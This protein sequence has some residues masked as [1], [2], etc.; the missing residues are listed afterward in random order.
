[1]AEALCHKVKGFCHLAEEL[2]HKVE[3]LCHMAE[4]SNHLVKELCHVAE[5]PNLKADHL[6][7]QVERLCHLAEASNH[8]AEAFDETGERKKVAL[9]D[10]RFVADRR[11][12]PSKN[13]VATDTDSPAHESH[14][15][16][17]IHGNAAFVT[18]PQGE[19]KRD[20]LRLLR[21]GSRT[22]VCSTNMNQPFVYQNYRDTSSHNHC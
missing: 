6:C 15:C 13:H 4:R 22:I 10:A 17:H 11:G 1:M 16:T 20:L 18:E 7:H 3:G 19:V 14:C 12:R 8:V 2:C 5:V 21:R 9:N